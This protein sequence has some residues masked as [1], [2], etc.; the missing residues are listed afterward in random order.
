MDNFDRRDFLKLAGLGGVVFASGL[1]GCSS[2]EPYASDDFYFVQLSDIHWGFENPAINP[3]NK[4]TLPKAIAAV[5]SLDKKPDFV[6]FTGDLSQ[7]TD[8]PKLRRARMKEVQDLAA[9]LKVPQVRFFAGEHDAALDRGEAYQELFGE[10]LH[11]TFEHK[12]VHFIVLDNVSDP[13]PILGEK[14]IAWLKADLAKQKPDQQIVVLTHRP[15]FPMYPQWD[16]AT[17]DGQ[18]AI[19]A[20]MPFKNVSVYYGHVHHENHTRTGHIMHNSANSLS[21]PLAPVGTAEKKTQI[22]W[23]PA[24][25]YKS[26]GWREL[27]VDPDGGEPKIF[28]QAIKA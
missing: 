18:Q 19:D 28:E 2:I 9:G 14:Q 17:R 5:N 7:T 13:A 21:F 24:Q 12:G 1:P 4:G 25:P 11:Y 27:L 15:L 10:T 23:N 20:L 6:V 22:P 26:L 3:D 16:W 8:N